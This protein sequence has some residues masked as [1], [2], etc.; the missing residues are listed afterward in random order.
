MSLTGLRAPLTGRV[1]SFDEA[2]GWGVIA[3]DGG[4]E[5]PFH[6]TAIA[7]GTRAI[8]VGA[9]VTFQLMPGHRGQWEAAGITPR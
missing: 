5:Y 1:A 2:T 7:D 9:A 8:E 3:V 6:C 4:I